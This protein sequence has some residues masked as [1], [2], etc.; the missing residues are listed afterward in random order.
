MKRIDERYFQKG[1]DSGKEEEIADL[2]NEG[3]SILWEGKPKKSSFILSSVLRFAIPALIFL[4]FDVAFLCILL[5]VIHGAPWFVYL[6]Y[7]VFMLFHLL[8][9]WIWLSSV[10]SASKR[11]EKEDYAFT[12]RRILVKKGFIG[13]TIVSIYYPSITSV[14]VRVGLVERMCKVGDIYILAGAQ[15]VVLED[16]VDASFIASK[17]QRIAEDVKADVNYPNALR[18]KENPGYDTKLGK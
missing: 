17:L 10:L 5:F 9:F 4:C 14:N 7:G 8:P 3:E 12:E 13:S 15:K 11:Q 6:I 2:L 16:I 1:G 18:P